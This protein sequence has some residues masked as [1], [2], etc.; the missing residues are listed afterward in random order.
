MEAQ[1][2]KK[3]LNGSTLKGAKVRIEDAKRE[4]KRKSDDEA[5]E[6]DR[7]SRKAAKKEKARAEK[8]VVAGHELDEGRHVKRGWTQDENKSN[9][10]SVEGKK[11][12]FK[13]TVPPNVSP[14]EPA[15][16]VEKKKKDK[17]KSKSDKKKVVVEE[18]GT[19]SKP[20]DSPLARDQFRVVTPTQES[21]EE[22]G[23]QSD[24]RRRSSRQARQKQPRISAIESREVVEDTAPHHSAGAAEVDD[25]DG[26]DVD[27]P[28]SHNEDAEGDNEISKPVGNT[29]EEAADKQVHPLEALF[30]RPAVPSPESSKRRPKP[31]DTS[32]NFFDTE[33]GGEDDAVGELAPQ[34]PHTKRDLEWRSLR[35][36]AP[37]PDTAALGRRFSIAHGD[38]DEEDEDEDVEDEQDVEMG[39]G[40]QGGER[41][42]QAEGGGGREGESAFRK[43]FYENRGDFN[44]GWK[45]RRRDEKKQLRQRENRR[46][47]RKV[48]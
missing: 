9:G 8:G 18:F 28:A 27:Q 48:A 32:F 24:G 44:R 33:A 17:T 2:L 40:E 39:D 35:S 47:S 5:E 14:V 6:G 43:W 4:K 30:K 19:H 23:N 20:I 41:S 3:K 15:S 46:L 36:A 42:G 45:K 1:K 29:A 11:L 7:K 21:T 26:M 22:D 10:S 25:N 34:T 38:T 37:T 31:I 16:K 12:R 13:T